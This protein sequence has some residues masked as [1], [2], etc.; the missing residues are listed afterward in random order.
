MKIFVL[1]G[2]NQPEPNDD[3]FAG[4]RFWFT[5]LLIVWVLSSIGL[6]WVINSVLVLFSL[7]IVLPLMVALGFGAYYLIFLPWWVNR[8]A[9][10]DDCPV[11]SHT[12]S[13]IPTGQ[14]QCP[15]CGEPLQVEQKK[16]V[17]FTPPGIID[18]EVQTVD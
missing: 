14:F 4:L 8:N 10:I 11:C 17:R 6:G 5:F 16:F 12:F 1:N 18:V 2:G 7:A 15:N 13:A 9:V 3:R